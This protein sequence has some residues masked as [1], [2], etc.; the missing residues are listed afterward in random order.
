MGL[1]VTYKHVFAHQDV[2]R[3]HWID[4]TPEAGPLVFPHATTRE[5]PG[6]KTFALYLRLHHVRRRVP[7]PDFEHRAVLVV[8]VGPRSSTGYSLRVLSVTEQRNRVVVKLREHT[9]TTSDPG[10]IR[11]VYP[12]RMI[13]FPRTGKSTFVT[14]EGRP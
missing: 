12:Y 8:A 3:L 2:R 14:I 1:W 7:P 13:T 5:L 6:P 11:I 10:S 9:P 4:L